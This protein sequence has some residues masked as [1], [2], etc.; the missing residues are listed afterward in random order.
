VN[1]YAANEVGFAFRRSKLV[2][3]CVLSNKSRFPVNRGQ[4]QRHSFSHFILATI[5]EK[6]QTKTS[7]PAFIK[8]TQIKRD[9]S[10][11]QRLTKI[12]I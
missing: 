6:Y 9:D 1:K 12:C 4:K 8:A 11:S 3:A 5:L 10:D 2:P 7:T